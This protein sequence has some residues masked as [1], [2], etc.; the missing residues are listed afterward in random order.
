MTIPEL[1]QKINQKMSAGHH[2]DSSLKGLSLGDVPHAEGRRIAIVHTEWNEEV[3]GALVHGATKELLRQNKSG[4]V[5]IEKVGAGLNDFA[6][7]TSFTNAPRR[8]LPTR[9]SPAPSS[10]R[11]RARDYKGRWST[12]RSSP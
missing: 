3:V 7:A 2:A 9:R 1:H 6:F 12:M 8:P 5:Y 4:Q 11:T 10:S